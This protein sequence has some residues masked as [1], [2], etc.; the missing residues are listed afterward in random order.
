MLQFLLN[1]VLIKEAVLPA[2]TTV[3]DYL[4]EHRGR[5]GSKEGCASGDC[6]ACT[7]VVAELAEDEQGNDTLRYRS[8][9][10][11]IT[12]AGALHAKQLITVEDLSGSNSSENTNSK[13]TVG[14]ANGNSSLHVCQQAMVDSHASQC[15]FCTPGIVMSLFAAMKNLQQTSVTRSVIDQQLGGNLCRCTGYRPIIQAAEAAI[16]NSEP[17]QFDLQADKTVQSLKALAAN[18]TTTG[19]TIDPEIVPGFF[20]P[21]TLEQLYQLKSEHPQAMVLAGGTDLALRVTQQLETIG[22]II[23]LDG[24]DDLSFI[25]CTA[26]Q[27]RIGAGT[28][29]TEFREFI[30]KLCPELNDLLVRF[31]GTQVRNQATVGGNFANA[32]PVGDLPPVFI[33]LQAQVVL[34]SSRGERT[35]PVDEFFVSYKETL[36]AADEIIREFVIPTAMLNNNHSSQQTVN[37]FYKISKRMEDDISAVCAAFHLRMENDRVVDASIAFGGMAATPKR[38]QHL[39]TA[40]LGSVLDEACFK[41][42]EVALQSDFQP[43]SDVRATSA[44]RQTVSVNLLRRLA[45]EIHHPQVATSVAGH[46]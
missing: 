22:G 37:R 24:V 16:C 23:L 11:C 1:N 35:V 32:S 4:R 41:K 14:I 21:V 28:C 45:I 30:I 38:A 43:L 7:V 8:I 40:L 25:D 18:N 13:A 27:I 3:L 44:Y 34:A 19:S 10:S 33:A 31:A 42:A 46:E 15:G 6:G 26:Q 39:E 2:D 29:V 20:R 5:C 17:D 12:F 36:L 9:N